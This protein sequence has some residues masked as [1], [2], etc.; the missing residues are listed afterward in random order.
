MT[1]HIIPLKVYFA[2]TAAL[3][4]LLVTTILVP[5]VDLG[6]YN[7]VVALM[8]ATIK[9]TLV[10]LYFMEVRYSSRLTWL[11]AI[12]GFAWLLLLLGLTFSDY[13]NRSLIMRSIG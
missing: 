13:L 4:V 8:I 12:A 2:V 7:A 5:M 1:G 9:A 3:M 10:V 6:P 11:F